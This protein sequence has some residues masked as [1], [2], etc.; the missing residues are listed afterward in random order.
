MRFSNQLLAHAVLCLTLAG[1]APGFAQPAANTQPRDWA[2]VGEGVLDLNLVDCSKPVPL[3]LVQSP[4]HF[5]RVLLPKLFVSD[6]YTLTSSSGI[7][8]FMKSREGRTAVDLSGSIFIQGHKELVSIQDGRGATIIL[9][10]QL[11]GRL[12]PQAEAFSFLQFQ[13]SYQAQKRMSFPEEAGPNLIPAK[14]VIRLRNP[15]LSR[16]LVIEK[17]ENRRGGEAVFL[18]KN[19][20]ECQDDDGVA[21]VP[22]GTKLIGR[23]LFDPKDNEGKNTLD[24]TVAVYP[25]GQPREVEGTV[26]LEGNSL[27]LDWP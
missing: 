16:C 19:D 13:S 6:R 2:F 24:L 1:Q 18:L 14:P 26:G 9:V 11:A 22:T 17:L 23:A 27:R 12:P 3:K 4:G 21:V 20:L 5:V 7:D 15:L 8:V 25:D 10:V